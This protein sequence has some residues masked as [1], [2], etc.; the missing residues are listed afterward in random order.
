VLDEHGFGDHGTCA[1]RPDESGDG[2]QQMEKQN[3][4]IAHRASRHP[5]K[6]AIQNCR[7]IQQF[8]THTLRLRFG[9]NLIAEPAESWH[10]L[11]LVRG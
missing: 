6:T 1:T 11:W 9:T 4:H 7:R 2:R 3:G 10:D 8:A 5:T